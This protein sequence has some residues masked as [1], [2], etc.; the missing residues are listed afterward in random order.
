MNTFE[1]GKRLVELCKQDK[2]LEAIDTLY[3]PEI[4]SLEPRATTNTDIETRGLDAIRKKNVWWMQTQH[5]NSSSV[6]GP[7]VNGD[8][9]SVNFK[10][11]I[12]NKKNGKRMDL[13]EVGLYTVQ[14]NKIVKEEFF[15]DPESFA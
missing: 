15:S 9:F 2:H 6:E 10:Y 11:D 13:S 1:T 12:T 4:I 5:V 14:N 3:S 8:R 7:Y